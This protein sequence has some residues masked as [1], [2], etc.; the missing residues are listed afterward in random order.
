ML[1]VR[2]NSTLSTSCPPGL[3]P[4]T[5]SVRA[6]WPSTGMAARRDPD[7]GDRRTD[8]RTRDRS[9]HDAPLDDLDSGRPARPAFGRARH[10]RAATL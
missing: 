6:V 5:M 1:Y 4:G 9:M 10:D 7:F 2:F 8:S 3:T